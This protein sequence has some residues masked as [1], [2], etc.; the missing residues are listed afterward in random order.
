MYL[1]KKLRIYFFDQ[2]H[3]LH[4]KRAIEFLVNELNVCTPE[5]AVSRIFFISAKEVLQ[6]RVNERNGQAL[7]RGALAE[8][9]RSRYEKFEEF[10]HIF[11]DLIS[12]SAIQ[13]K[14]LNHS[15]QGKHILK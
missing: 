4:V 12:K 9:C 1:F 14:F 10:E 8:G 3:K 2:V 13:T 6:A 7:N 15:Q 5:E 11:E